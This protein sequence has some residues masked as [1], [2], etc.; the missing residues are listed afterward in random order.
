MKTIIDLQNIQGIA[1]IQSIN[2]LNVAGKYTWNTWFFTYSGHVNEL[3]ASFYSNGWS[4]EAEPKVMS[5]ELNEAG[6]QLMYWFIF[7]NLSRCAQEDLDK[8]NV[9][10]D[11][12]SDL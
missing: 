1:T 4:V 8:M 11:L 2:D 9:K 12:P 6:I 5:A 3:R 10:I 7:S